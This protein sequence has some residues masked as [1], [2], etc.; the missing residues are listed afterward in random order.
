MKRP[1]SSSVCVNV[2]PPPPGIGGVSL[3][4]ANLVLHGSNGLAGATYHLLTS[5]DLALPLSQWTPVATN[6]L[7]A[8]GNFT[9][10]LTNA[11]NANVL[12]RFYIL[13]WP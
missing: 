2:S 6:N 7:S 10:T 13:Q 3:C 11:V 9:I 5:A 4:G 12:Q 8:S 1:G